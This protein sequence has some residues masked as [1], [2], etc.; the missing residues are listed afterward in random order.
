MVKQ[1]ALALSFF[2]SRLRA[3]RISSP[4]YHHPVSHFDSPIR[5]VRWYSYL[6]RRIIASYLRHPLIRLK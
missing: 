4:D 3:I 1:V 2:F 5:K 6:P